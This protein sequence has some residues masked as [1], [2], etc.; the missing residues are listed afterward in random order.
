MSEKLATLH[1]RQPRRQRA[2]HSAGGRVASDAPAPNARP[3]PVRGR[4]PAR[5]GRATACRGRGTRR[6]CVTRYRLQHPAS[7]QARR[8]L[9]EL[10][11]EGSKAY[12]DTNTSNHNHFLLEPTGELMDIPGDAIRVEGLPEPPEGHE[13]H[14]RRRGRAAVRRPDLAVVVC[15]TLCVSPS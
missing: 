11:I 1:V 7:V 15:A 4:R 6:A 9:R 10:A 2:R 3:A 8:L 14:T 12:F 5:D 13:D